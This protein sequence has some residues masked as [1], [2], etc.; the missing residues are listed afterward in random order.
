MEQKKVWIPPL[1]FINLG[2]VSGR[3]RGSSTLF[4]W[5]EGAPPPFNR[6]CPSC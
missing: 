5:F 3:T 1:V 6:R 4:P 2:P